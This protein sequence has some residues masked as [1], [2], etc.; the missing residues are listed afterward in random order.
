MGEDDDDDAVSKVGLSCHWLVSM[1]KEGEKKKREKK[2]C[3]SQDRLSH[4]GRI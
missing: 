4:A 2:S 1:V 3:N